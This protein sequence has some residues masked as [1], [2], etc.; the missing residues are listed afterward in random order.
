MTIRLVRYCLLF[1]FF[2]FRTSSYFLINIVNIFK[3]YSFSLS[4]LSRYTWL[5]TEIVR[6]NQ[7]KAI[8]SFNHLAFTAASSYELLTL[9]EKSDLLN[10]R[11]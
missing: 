7:Q 2:L 8:V 11:Q 10:Y 9:A 5:V 6:L 3:A 4:F 1:F